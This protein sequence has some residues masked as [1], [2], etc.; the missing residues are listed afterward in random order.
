MSFFSKLGEKRPAGQIETTWKMYT[1]SLLLPTTFLTFGQ[2]GKP[3]IGFL[4]LFVL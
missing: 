4:N 2:V 3:R 1:S